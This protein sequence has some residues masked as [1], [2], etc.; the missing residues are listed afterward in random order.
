MRAVQ[1]EEDTDQDDPNRAAQRMEEAKLVGGR[2]VICERT[3]L[4]HLVDE[5]PYSE[6]DEEQRN[7]EMDGVAV[8]YAG[9]ADKK[10]CTKH[11]QP[12]RSRRE[13][14]AGGARVQISCGSLPR[15][16]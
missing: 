1:K 14:A 9:V 3:S 4:R 2:A 5:Q 6:A 11:D 7:E 16:W 10:D 8:E 15:E 13:A 12:D